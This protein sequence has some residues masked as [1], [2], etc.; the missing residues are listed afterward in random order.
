MR[1]QKV[2]FL[3]LFIFPLHSEVY[4]LILLW[5]AVTMFDVQL[6]EWYFKII[7]ISENI[8][9]IMLRATG[10]WATWTSWPPRYI[11]VRRSSLKRT[12]RPNNIL[13]RYW[14]EFLSLPGQLSSL[15]Q[16]GSLDC[17]GISLRGRRSKG[18]GKGIRAR[19][20]A[21]GRREEGNACKEAIVFAIPPTD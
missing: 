18:K 17:T 16:L 14:R 5:K 7:I 11:L 21:R 10:C 3:S 20:H 13:T 12:S 9:W 1:W 8:R 2:I 15:Y 19:D 6:I 4:W